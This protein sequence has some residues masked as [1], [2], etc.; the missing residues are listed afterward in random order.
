MN[1]PGVNGIGLTAAHV[2][3]APN[4]GQHAN[5]ATQASFT[6]PDGGGTLEWKCQGTNAGVNNVSLSA[7][8][9]GSLHIN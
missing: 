8:R 6:L 3:G 4:G 9:V 7:I 2:P 5:L 1:V